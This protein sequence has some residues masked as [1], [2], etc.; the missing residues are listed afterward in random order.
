MDKNCPCEKIVEF[1][2]AYF[3]PNDPGLE[4][5]SSADCRE[6]VM[7]RL[8]WPTSADKNV[9]DTVPILNRDAARSKRAC[10]TLGEHAGG[11]V[12]RHQGLLSR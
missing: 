6:K 2:G 1:R 5:S 9:G 3:A 8:G 4:L 7:A 11:F 10:V 12:R